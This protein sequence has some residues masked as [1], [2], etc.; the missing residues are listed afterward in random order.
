MWVL[1]FLYLL[2]P[3]AINMVMIIKAIIPII[4]FEKSDQTLFF[5]SSVVIMFGSIVLNSIVGLSVAV[6]VV[7]TFSLGVGLGLSVDFGVTLVIGLL[8]GLIVGLRVGTG[9]AVWLLTQLQSVLDAQIGF[10][11]YPSK[12]K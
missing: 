3:K 4:N 10:L 5:K 1:F 2:N 12:Q 7:T 11:Q 6:S 9:V 8:V